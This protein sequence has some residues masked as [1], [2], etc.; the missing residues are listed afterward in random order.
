MRSFIIKITFTFILCF[1][2]TNISAKLLTR[3]NFWKS[4]ENYQ[5]SIIKYS[6]SNCSYCK[7]DI[8]DFWPELESKIEGHLEQKNKKN[9]TE[10]LLLLG[11]VNCDE[12]VENF[13]FCRAQES[14]GYP[15]RFDWVCED[16][17]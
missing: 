14:Y 15:V 11:E 9:I 5:F 12:N 13:Y 1:T 6:V 4:I 8:L 10:N 2:I 7:D 3:K 17:K 16:S